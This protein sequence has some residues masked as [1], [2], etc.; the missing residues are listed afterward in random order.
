[1]PVLLELLQAASSM[2]SSGRARHSKYF[3]VF[4]RQFLVQVQPGQVFGE[5]DVAVGRMLLRVVQGRDGDINRGGC[6]LR[7]QRQQ[8]TAV[9][10]EPAVG[11]RAGSE[12]AWL[13]TCPRKYIAWH[14]DPGGDDAA[15]RL[16]THAAMAMGD[17]DQCCVDAVLH[18]PA[19]TAAGTA[20]LVRGLAHFD[21]V[22][23]RVTLR[24]KT[25]ACVR[26]SRL[27]HLPTPL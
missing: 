21:Q 25:G 14:G 9:A 27:P 5:P 17:I 26:W 1:M 8:G 12:V 18:L 10:A 2:S 7:G 13:R 24:L 3:L 6:A 15:G 16:A 4:M 23:R 11:M 19:Q 20:R 22:S